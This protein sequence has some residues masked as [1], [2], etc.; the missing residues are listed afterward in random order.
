MK[1]NDGDSAEY[2]EMKSEQIEINSNNEAKL[3]LFRRWPCGQ[4]SGLVKAADLITIFSQFAEMF[5]KDV[6]KLLL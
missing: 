5:C 6:M 4:T 3:W 1:I 2:I